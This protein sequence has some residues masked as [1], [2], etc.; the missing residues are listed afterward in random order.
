MAPARI[1]FVELL[2]A[3]RFPGEHGLIAPLGGGGEFGAGSGRLARGVRGLFGLTR[4]GQRRLSLPV[5]GAHLALV[6]RHQYIPR[7]HA[8]AFP[9]AHRCDRTHE[10]RRDR[11]GGFSLNRTDR[12]INQRPGAGL[13]HSDHR[14][15]GRAGGRHGV[16]GLDFFAAACAQS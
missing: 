10:F 4:F 3:D 16:P 6:D 15:Y 7:P 5:L 2:A 12:L 1:D 13:G 14:L 11:A 8:V 9:H